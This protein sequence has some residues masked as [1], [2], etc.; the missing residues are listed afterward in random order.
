M[1]NMETDVPPSRVPETRASED[2]APEQVLL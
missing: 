1:H 2:K